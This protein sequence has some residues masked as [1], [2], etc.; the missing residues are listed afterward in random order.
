VMRRPIHP[1]DTAPAARG[2]I[3]HMSEATSGN[4]RGV[5]PTGWKSNR[6]EEHLSSSEMNGVGQC[7]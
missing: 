1:P 2:H 6:L 5:A 3:N 7:W 4:R